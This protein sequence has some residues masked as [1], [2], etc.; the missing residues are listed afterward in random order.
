MAALQGQLPL[1]EIERHL[2]LLPDRYVRTTGPEAVAIHLRLIQELQSD[3]FKGSWAQHGRTITE[4]T[5]CARDRHGLFADIA[6]TLTA[7][8]I[9]ILSAEINTREDGI[10][11]DVFMLRMA[12]NRQAIE[13]HKWITIERALRLAIKGDSDVAALVEKWQ[14]HHAPRRRS[15]ATNARRRNLPQVVCDNQAAQ[16]ATIVEVRAVDAAGLAYKIASVATAL[17]FEIVYAK[18][19]TEKSDAFDVFYVTDAE[20]M[21]L[22]EDAM[23]ALESATLERLSLTNGLAPS[24][25]KR[26]SHAG[27]NS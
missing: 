2:A 10:A 3:V 24:S 20:G 21:R 4:L 14:T 6:G 13:E 25:L 9:E 19:T 23:Q 11:I 16:S 26:E 8:G 17:G 1:S 22:S 27:G 15:P 18:I 7:Q 12:A 5:I